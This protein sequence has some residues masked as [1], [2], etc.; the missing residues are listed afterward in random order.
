VISS[1]KVGASAM[2]MPGRT[3]SGRGR[4]PRNPNAGESGPVQEGTGS[5]HGKKEQMVRKDMLAH[6]AVSTQCGS[7]DMLV[8][9]SG[10]SQMPLAAK[11]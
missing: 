7:L 2:R 6:G 9:R 3:S 4:L 1:T 5:G 11:T 10:H 8:W